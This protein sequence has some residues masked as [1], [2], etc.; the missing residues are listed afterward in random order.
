MS[1]LSEYLDFTKE[2]AIEAGEIMYSNFLAGS[3]KEWKEDR[4]PL[5]ATDTQINR[6]V[7]EM[8]SKK[9]PA[10]SILGEEESHNLGAQL[11]WVCDPVD[12]TMPFSHGLPISTFSLALTENGRPIVGAVYEPYTKRLFWASKEGGAFLNNKAIHVN[13]NQTLDHALIDMAGI[14]FSL[15]PVVKIKEG[16]LRA[17]YEKGVYS[18]QLWS[19]ILPSAL[20]AAGQY[21]ATIFNI[22]KPEDAAAIKLI[23]EEAGGKVTDLFGNE[24]LY[25]QPIK[26]FI[27]SNGHIHHDLVNLVAKFITE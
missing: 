20:I 3:K 26:G 8:I 25:N 27:A 2:L 4:T 19:I 9:F 15:L 24:Q 13:E 17:L 21:S 1:S 11:T 12:G 14:P 5:T 23:V 10:H 16:F 18:T 6:L 22:T 7:I